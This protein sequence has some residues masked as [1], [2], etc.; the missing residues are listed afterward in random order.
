MILQALKGYYDRKVADP[1]SGIAPR[2]LEWKEISFVI[3]LDKTGRF[4]KIESWWDNEGKKKTGHRFLVP[5]GEKKANGIKANLLWDTANYVFGVASTEGLTEKERQHTLSRLPKQQKAFIERIE[6]ELPDAP[7]KAAVLRFLSTDI[8]IL[9]KDSNW[10]EVYQTNPNITFRFEDEQQI[11]CESDEI[12]KVVAAKIAAK[13]ADGRCLIT[14][15]QDTISTLHTAIKGVWGAQR[16]GAN[17]VS[18]NLDSF[19]WFG[20][21]QGQNSPVGEAAMFA[22][23]TALNHL[24]DKKSSQRMQ[25]GDA[26]TVF[27]SDRETNFENIFGPFFTGL[28]KDNPDDETN[29]IKE[30]LESPKSGAYIENE[31]D[32]KFF[33]LGLSPNAARI[34]IRFWQVGPIQRFKDNIYQHFLDLKICKPEREPKYYTLKQLLLSTAVQNKEENIP[35]NL[36]GDFM[37]SILDSPYTP[38]PATLL[39]AVLR[40]IRSDTAKRVTPVRAALLKAYFNRYERYYNYSNRKELS[41]RL[42]RDNQPRAYHLGSLFAVLEKI[43]EEANPRLNA[44]I[45]ERYYGAACGTPAVVFPTLLRLK[46]HHLAK[47]EH[48]GRK[49]FFEKLIAEIMSYYD[50]FPPQHDLHEQG[51]FAIGYYHQRQEFFITT[52]DKPAQQ[53]AQS[54][55]SLLL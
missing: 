17:I 6:N 15:E 29:D 19:R 37:R 34:S 27:W 45:R 10:S 9:E 50:D 46:N 38:Y 43:Q 53:S 24:L 13:V 25:V 54:E 36:A 5:Q 42:N 44:T 14:G 51:K 18:F 39:Q 26:S 47:L 12:K 30:L 23:T 11:Y 16:S 20:K 41:V 33:V 7:K 35:S 3:L 40:R 32:T 2:G 22:Y 55:Q 48:K 52:K 21:K 49:V 1:T 4:I 31:K 28:P 8:S